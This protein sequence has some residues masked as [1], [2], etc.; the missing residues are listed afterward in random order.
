MLEMSVVIAFQK[1][2]AGSQHLSLMPT[3]PPQQHNLHPSALTH[4]KGRVNPPPQQK[5]ARALDRKQLEGDVPLRKA[6]C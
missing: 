5:D 4:L 3:N 2:A 6:T 1:I